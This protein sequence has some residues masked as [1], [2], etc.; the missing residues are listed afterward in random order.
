MVWGAVIGA[1]ASLAGGLLANKGRSDAAEATNAFN[2]RMRNTQYQAAVKDMKAAGLNPM[3]AYQQGG[4]ASP[5]GVTADV[6][7]VI[8]PAVNTARQTAM[9][10]Q[11]YENL[12]AQVEKT[13]ADTKTQE[14]LVKYQDVLRSK[15]IQDTITTALQGDR[16]IAQTKLLDSQREKNILDTLISGVHVNTAKT[17]GEQKALDLQR[18]S[19]FG[20]SIIGK[21]SEGIVRTLQTGKK[22][23]ENNDIKSDAKAL[24]NTLKRY[25]DITR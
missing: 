9:A 5:A 1:A 4:N 16:E 11:E 21:E 19:R 15:A 7:D 2:E 13:K 10:E 22:Y 14:S 12:K 24:W 25:F 6:Q 8:S 3:L 20:D 18:S 17:E 23:L